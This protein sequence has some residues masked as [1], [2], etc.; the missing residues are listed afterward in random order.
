MTVIKA[1]DKIDKIV[2]QIDFEALHIEIT[3]KNCNYT[4]DKTKA[5]NQIGFDVK[6]GESHDV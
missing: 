6:G 4:L 2:D 3:T 1:L 5:K